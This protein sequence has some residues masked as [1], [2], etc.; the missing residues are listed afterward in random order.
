MIVRLRAVSPEKRP[1]MGGTP[2]FQ[3]LP[4]VSMMTRRALLKWGLIGG[5]GLATGCVS[6]DGAADE[7]PLFVDKEYP[8]GFLA[9]ED[10]IIIAAI[11]P[12]MLAGALPS[13]PE[14]LNVR[15]REIVRG[16]DYATGLLT[17]AVRAELR[18]LFGV[19]GSTMGRIVVA[20]VWSHWAKVKPAE[21]AKFLDN[22]RN[23]YLDLLRLGYQ[24]LHELIMAS[25]Y[26]NP[27]SWDAIGYPGP[28]Q[29]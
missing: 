17:D 12:V 25:W 23:A 28:P 24:G 19:L 16:V 20:G 9:E 11:A 18:E 7:D 5:A 21:V 22:W 2:I 29:V 4:S 1:P 10:R 14:E 13:D 3:A 8:Y 26:G 15:L 6:L 27:A